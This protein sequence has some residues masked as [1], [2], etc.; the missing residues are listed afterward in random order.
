[1]SIKEIA[2]Q[3]TGVSDLSELL[4]FIIYLWAR[5]EAQEYA[6]LGFFLGCLPC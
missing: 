3:V 1:M 4:P 6:L 2:I 5:K